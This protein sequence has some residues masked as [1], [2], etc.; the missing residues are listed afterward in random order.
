MSDTGRA[1]CNS[2]DL[3]AGTGRCCL[4]YGSCLFHVI[5]VADREELIRCSCVFQ[6]FYKV[7]VH[8]ESGKLSQ[9]VQMNIILCI[10]CCDQKQKIDRLSVERFIFNAVR[11]D[12]CCKSRALD[13]VAFAVRDRDTV[14]DTGCSL[15]LT[16]E[17]LLLVCLVVGNVARFLHQGDRHFQTLRLVGRRSLERNAL[18]LQKVCD[19]HIRTPFNCTRRFHL[20]MESRS[21][22]NPL[23]SP[24]IM[25]TEVPFSIHTL[26]Y[27]PFIE[28]PVP[29][30]SLLSSF[31]RYRG[32]D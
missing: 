30:P 31:R 14:A 29:V 7:F 18:L 32:R 24:F 22:V 3:L 23:C 15:C 11:N 1:C 5:L 19:S 10:G 25:K 2:E 6:A 9:Y 17:D 16:E 8:E 26:F 12:H 21:G 13:C 4:L 27:D 20:L 28:S